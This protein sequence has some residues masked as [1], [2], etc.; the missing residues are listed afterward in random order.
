ACG[1][2][3]FLIQALDRLVNE[4][5]WLATERERVSGTAVLWDGDTVTKAV[6]ANN[7]YGVDINEESIE[8]TRLAL[9]LHTALPDRPLSSLDDN[10]RCGNSL[11][12]RQFYKY[13]QE[14]LF[15]EEER[16]RINAFD[17]K[18]AFPKVFNRP[19]DKSGFDCVIGNP[20]Y[21]KL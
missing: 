5:Q 16:E 4:R 12:D 2:G 19:E 14:E 18:V 7:I 11:I 9:W 13:K 17:W 21:V 6:L 8:I 1:S 3:A 10:I 15:D 20:P